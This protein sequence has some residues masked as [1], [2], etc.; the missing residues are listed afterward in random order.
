[1]I[2]G[3]KSLLRGELSFNADIVEEEDEE[4]MECEKER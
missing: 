4:G 1:M 2:P 3:I